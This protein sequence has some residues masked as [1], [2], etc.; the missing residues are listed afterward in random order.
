VAR[1][2]ILLT[3]KYLLPNEQFDCPEVLWFSKLR[4]SLGVEAELPLWK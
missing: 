4:E 2:I 1:E 3:V